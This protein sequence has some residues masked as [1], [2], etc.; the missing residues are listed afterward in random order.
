MLVGFADS[1][2]CDGGLFL[3]EEETSH[4]EQIPLLA[5]RQLDD[6]G[7]VCGEVWFRQPTCRT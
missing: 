3:E 4:P 1:A 2:D 6:D 5:L 7:L